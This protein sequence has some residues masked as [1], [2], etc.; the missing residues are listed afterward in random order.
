[1]TLDELKNI[2][3]SERVYLPEAGTLEISGE[4]L[5]STKVDLY[6]VLLD[7]SGM[8]DYTNDGLVLTSLLSDVYRAGFGGTT[9]IDLQ[10][11]L[12]VGFALMAPLPDTLDKVFAVDKYSRPLSLKINDE[13]IQPIQACPFARC[14][15]TVSEIASLRVPNDY[16]IPFHLLIGPGW[17]IGKAAFVNALGKE[18]CEA[19]FSAFALQQQFSFLALRC[20]SI[21]RIKEPFRLR[22][23]GYDG[24]VTESPLLIPTAGSFE[25]YLFE[26]EKGGFDNVPMSGEV[27]YDPS[28]EFEKGTFHSG[29]RQ[30]KSTRSDIFKQNSGFLD[31]ATVDA[32]ARLMTSPNIYHLKDGIWKRI[33]LTESSLSLSKMN[34]L[35]SITFTYTYS[36]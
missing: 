10:K 15:Q 17:T 18:I 20:I 29:V 35:H 24:S 4:S 19:D 25:Q 26:N 9:T 28:I 33:V 11:L 22:Y 8:L 12:G 32:L 30:T 16:V 14:G 21:P 1:M 27:T 2:I 34:S 31:R 36:E 3:E 5:G 23:T 13:Y 7:G 6:S